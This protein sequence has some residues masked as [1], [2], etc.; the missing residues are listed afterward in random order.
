MVT[1]APKKAIFTIPH[2]LN[3]QNATNFLHFPELSD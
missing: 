3:R 1:D 2:S